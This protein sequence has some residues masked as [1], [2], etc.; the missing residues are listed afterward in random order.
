M[1]ESDLLDDRILSR[2]IPPRRIWDLFS[3]RVVPWWVIRMHPR[4]VSHAWVDE[5]ERISV[6]TAINGYAW[7]VP[8]PRGVDLRLLRIEL[9]EL[10]AE[11]AWVDVLCLRQLGGLRKDK[12]E[13]EWRLDVPTIGIVYDEFWRRFCSIGPLMYYFNGLGRPM[14]R[15]VD[16]ESKRSWFQRA[17]TLQEMS[18]DYLIGGETSEDV[19]GGYREELAALRHIN[20]TP[21]VPNLG[22]PLSTSLLLNVLKEM[23]TRVS[24][25]PRDKVAGLSYLF[26]L[27]CIPAYSPSQNEEDVWSVIVRE[28]DLRVR[29]QLFF[30]YPRPG[31]GTRQ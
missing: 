21:D 14:G 25:N 22:C 17:W 20:G 1:R 2:G 11:F 6:W 8:L 27:R 18:V 26:L 30:L 5:A 9:L 15:H 3:N 29:G 19:E 16:L 13:L 10:G 24:T 31:H 23:Q 7:P 12:R 4:G 28:M